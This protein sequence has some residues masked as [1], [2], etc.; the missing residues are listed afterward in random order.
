MEGGG[1]VP[2]FIIS[3]PPR[4]SHVY[5]P[6]CRKISSTTNDA[7]RLKTTRK[8]ALKSW[9][10]SFLE[11]FPGMIYIHINIILFRHPLSKALYLAAFSR[12][13]VNDEVRKEA[14]KLR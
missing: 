12:E 9:L 7:P 11:F 6:D 13:M 5:A 14:E 1:K 2:I 8:F 3:Y 10:P 4:K